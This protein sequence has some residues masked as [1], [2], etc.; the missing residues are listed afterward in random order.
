[1]LRSRFTFSRDGRGCSAI[2]ILIVL[3]CVG[4]SF[5]KCRRKL[6]LVLY[7]DVGDHTVQ[8]GPYLAKTVI[9]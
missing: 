6:V 9:L 1:M 2:S 3:R 8:F 4:T 5:G 7:I